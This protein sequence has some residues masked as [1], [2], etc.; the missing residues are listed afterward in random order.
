MMNPLDS[1]PTKSEDFS[2]AYYVMIQATAIPR[3]I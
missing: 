2:H 1:H 3:E